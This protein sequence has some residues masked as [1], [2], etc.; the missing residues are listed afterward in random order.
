MSR[1]GELKNIPTYD[2]FGNRTCRKV[3]GSIPAVLKNI[4]QLAR[5]KYKIHTSN[6]VFPGWKTPSLSL[7]ATHYL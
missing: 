6:I 4:F 1:P 3:V 7:T 2:Q 5:C